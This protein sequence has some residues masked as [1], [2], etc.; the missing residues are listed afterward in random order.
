MKKVSIV[1]PCYNESEGLPNFVKEIDRL[2]ADLPSYKLELVLV[3]D[4]SSDRTFSILAE[5]CSRYKWLKAINL[6]RNFGKKLP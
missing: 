6:T 3:N 4:G 1:A 2:I 5:L